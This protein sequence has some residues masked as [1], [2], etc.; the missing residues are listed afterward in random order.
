LHGFKTIFGIPRAL[1]RGGS[2]IWKLLL[3]SQ[4]SAF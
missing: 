3:I 1:F 2:A 4:H